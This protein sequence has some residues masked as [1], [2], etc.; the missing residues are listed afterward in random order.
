MEK[1]QPIQL[2]VQE[3]LNIHPEK[4]ENRSISPIQYINK[5]GLKTY[6]KPETLKQLEEKTGNTT[7]YRLRQELSEWNSN[8]T[9][10]STKSEQMELHEITKLMFSTENSQQDQQFA[11]YI[12]D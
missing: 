8:S 12:A 7:R 5:S 10:N 6:L 4:N 11:S 9:G 3:K 2:V 1:R